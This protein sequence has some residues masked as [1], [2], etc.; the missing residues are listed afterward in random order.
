MSYWS[1]TSKAG[2][3]STVLEQRPN[4]YGLLF[5]N[6]SVT[7]A[8]IEQVAVED[9]SKK[10]GRIV[11][12]V[13]LA[14]PHAGIFQAARDERNGIIQPDELDGLGIYSIHASV[15][16][17]VLH[18]LCANMNRSDLAPIVYEAWPNAITP[19]NG[20]WSNLVPDKDKETSNK[21]AVDEIFGWDSKTANAKPPIFAKYPLEHNTIMN[22][23][24]FPWGRDSIYLL[25]RGVNT[26]GESYVLCQMKVTMTANCSTRY[27]ATGSGG[28]M[29]AIC[30]DETDDLAYIRSVTNAT[31]KA[32][33]LDWPNIGEEWA[34]SVSLNT[35][36]VDA[37][38]SNSRLLTQ[39]ILTKPELNPGLPSPAE[40]LAVMAGCTLLMSS[41]DTP[42]VEYY[43]R[44]SSFPSLIVLHLPCL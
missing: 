29:E 7:P 15:P 24:S 3:G 41:Q 39:F 12:N 23:T 44:T 9:S 18:V 36:I 21:T 19:V 10:F 1:A 5:D 11:N 6:T 43:V 33:Q 20:S 42:F 28:T 2:N 22:H 35:G 37:N 34:N 25:G 16:S 32:K 30:E 26:E 38:A 17:P 40:A 13:S 31:S 4:G 14:M 8:W 27:N